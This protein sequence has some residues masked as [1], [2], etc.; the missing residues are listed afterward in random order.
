MNRISRSY[1]TWIDFSSF[2]SLAGN[3]IGDDDNINNN[4]YKN[5]NNDDNPN[6]LISLLC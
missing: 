2:L 5:Y 6:Y 3:I 1:N 4:K